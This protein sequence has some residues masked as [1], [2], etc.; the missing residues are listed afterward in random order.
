MRK[1]IETILKIKKDVAL[2]K[3]RSKGPIIMPSR[4]RTLGTDSST[5]H[6]TPGICT[7][8]E[9]FTP[10][11]LMRTYGALSFSPKPDTT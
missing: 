1:E 11:C 10:K 6:S 8:I 2:G 7:D 5:H 4:S 3:R 9:T